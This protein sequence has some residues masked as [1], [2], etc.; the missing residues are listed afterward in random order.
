MRKYEEKY[1]GIDKDPSELKKGEIIGGWLWS[2][3]YAFVYLGEEND[4]YKL[5]DIQTGLI[6]T[7]DRK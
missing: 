2:N 7:S 6:M 4:R 3:L 1:F 5:Y